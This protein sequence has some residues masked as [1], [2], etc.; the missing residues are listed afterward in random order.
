MGISIKI[1]DVD[2]TE[3]ADARSLKIIDELTSR[4][5]SC[6]FDFICNDTALAPIDGQTIL[7]E[8]GATK[9]FSG[10]V[11]SKEESFLPPTLLKYKVECIDYTRDLDKKLVFE[12]YK[13]CL[14]GNI[15]K[16][17]VDTYLTGF[18]Y[19]NVANGYIIPDISFDYVQVSEAITKIA[20]ICGYEWYIDYDK[21]IHFFALNTYTAPF[22]LDD[23]Q[24]DHK[25]LVINADISQLR[26]RVY[27]KSSAL[28]GTFGETFIY[29]GE[30]EEWIC[31]FVPIN[32][33]REKLPDPEPAP[34]RDVF[35]CDFSHDDIYLAMSHD[36][37]VKIASNPNKGIYIYKRYNDSFTQL[38]YPDITPDN[39]GHDVSF[40]PDSTYLAVVH[41]N[42][43]YL[44]IYKRSED[45]FTKLD[46]PAD[47]PTGDGWGCSFS[48]DGIYLAVAHNTSP[49]I[50]IYKRSGDAFAKLDNP[51]GGLPAGDG[52]GCK[53]SPN[54]VYL[55]VA[56]KT[57]PFI[58]C[59]KWCYLMPYR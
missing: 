56:H 53:F 46:N 47:L 5:N 59:N 3:F 44:M 8:D 10:R 22:D 14:A 41:K 15:I 1:A 27:V 52:Y 39:D 19:D 28:Q 58:Y 18:T 30:T 38:N 9:L 31:K 42:S 4:V 55:A 50:T 26:N 13:N 40:S 21:D 36:K 25:D 6:S 24:A 16:H 20:E 35:R 23:E 57:T 43:P 7:I 49:Y 17:I 29:D 33:G 32:R 12:S 11:L 48:P 37:T 51:V 34:T 2:R 54:G 45:T